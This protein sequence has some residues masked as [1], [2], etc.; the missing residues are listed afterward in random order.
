MK[1]I[2][3]RYHESKGTTYGILSVMDGDIIKTSVQTVENT[4]RKIKKGSYH[5]YYGYSPKFGRKLYS[6]NVPERTGIRIHPANKGEELKGCIAPV[7]YIDNNVGVKS[8]DALRL[9]EKYLDDNIYK[10]IIN[11]KFS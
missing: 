2:L 4:E 10:F 9:F 8:R 5:T 11:E 7:K 1:I 6:V 3:D